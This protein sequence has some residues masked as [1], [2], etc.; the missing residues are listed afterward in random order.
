MWMK[1]RNRFEHQ[2]RSPVATIA[3]AA[4]VIAAAA[5]PAAAQLLPCEITAVIHYTPPLTGTSQART[6]KAEEFLDACATTIAA[7]DTYGWDASRA[8]RS[9][10]N[11]WTDPATGFKWQEP[12]GTAT[13]NCTSNTLTAT[14]VIRWPDPQNVTIVEETTT[15]S[16]WGIRSTGKVISSVTL[17]AVDRRPGQPAT[18]TLS[19]NKLVRRSTAAVELSQV[20]SD[21]PLECSSTGLPTATRQGQF[22]FHQDED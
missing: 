21:D 4:I 9:V 14:H 19:T 8:T 18:R 12:L 17:T 11:V 2:E 22:F 7:G 20:N 6:F 16:V 1:T 5:G 10:G 3:L 15:S 13:G